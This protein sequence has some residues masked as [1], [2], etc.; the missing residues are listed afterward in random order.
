[1]SAD[2]K[3]PSMNLDGVNHRMRVSPNDNN[4]GWLVDTWSMGK[5]TLVNLPQAQAEALAVMLMAGPG[6]IKYTCEEHKKLGVCLEC[7]L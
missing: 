3:P 4:T 7:L 2:E 5:S 1:V 6:P